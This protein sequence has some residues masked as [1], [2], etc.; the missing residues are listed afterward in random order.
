MVGAGNQEHAVYL[1]SMQLAAHCGSFGYRRRG[2]VPEDLKQVF[3]I[4]L[5]GEEGDGVFPFGQSGPI[6]RAADQHKWH[7]LYR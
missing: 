4:S 3:R 5:S 1:A 2:V 7:N 6:G